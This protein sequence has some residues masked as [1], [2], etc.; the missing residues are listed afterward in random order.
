MHNYYNYIIHNYTQ[1][2]LFWMRLIISQPY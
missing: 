2:Q 1:L